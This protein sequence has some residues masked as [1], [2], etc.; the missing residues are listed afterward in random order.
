MKGLVQVM[1]KIIG[2]F[3]VL[4]TFALAGCQE[5]SNNQNEIKIG[6]VIYNQNDTFVS[7]MMTELLKY[8]E[9]KQQQTG[10]TIDIEV[11][12]ASD[13]QRTQNEQV[14]SLIN[15]GCDVICVNLVDRTTPSAIIDMAREADIPIVFFNREPVEEDLARWDKLYYVGADAS[16]SGNMQGELI[17]DYYRN[18]PNVDKNGDGYIQYVVIE[19]EAGHQDAIIR[20]ESCVKTM[21]NA[22]INLE[23]LDSE[24]ANWNKTQAQT[25]MALMLEKYGMNIELVICNND[26]MAL[27]AIDELSKIYSEKED[28]PIVVGIDGTEVGLRAV[29][30]GNMIGTVYN[31]KE[32]QARTILELAYSLATDGDMSGIDLINGKYIMLPHYKVTAE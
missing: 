21:E 3:L 29:R 12:N 19:G 26:D 24:I 14:E 18:N 2:I 31:D 11:N 22:G 7:A 5:N 4:M 6:V 16:E 9:E 20:T 10:Q 23:K 13:N 17:V 25:K 15:N 28:W 27:G 30:E 32:G 1:K 8:S